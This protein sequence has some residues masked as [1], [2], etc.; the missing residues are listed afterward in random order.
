MH[1][2]TNKNGKIGAGSTQTA[3]APR[4][5]A[6]RFSTAIVHPA[7]TIAAGANVDVPNSTLVLVLSTLPAQLRFYGSRSN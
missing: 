4:S 7:I 6:F 5:S 2:T 3:H 1:P